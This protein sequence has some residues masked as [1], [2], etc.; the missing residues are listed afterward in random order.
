[1]LKNIGGKINKNRHTRWCIVFIKVKGHLNGVRVSDKYETAAPDIFLPLL[2][3][4]PQVS[5]TLGKC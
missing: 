3:S 2:A 4:P 5:E 1:M